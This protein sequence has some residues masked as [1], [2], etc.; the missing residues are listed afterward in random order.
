MKKKLVCIFAHPDDETFMVGGTIAKLAKEY[1]IYVL[2]ATKGEAG[3][4]SDEETKRLGQMRAKELQNAADILGIKQVYFLGFKDGTLSNNLYHKLAEKI[5]KKLEQLRPDIILS[6]DPSGISGH[7]DHIT[8]AMVTLYVFHKVSFIKTLWQY[9]GKAE[10]A[11]K[12]SKNY[13]IHF[14]KGYTRDEVDKVIDIAD[15][16]DIKVR[17]MQQHKSQKHDVD[18]ILATQK[19][20]PKEDYFF[21]VKK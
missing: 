13:F 16:W 5:Q 2:C 20:L 18:R 10:V 12:M 19:H 15:V 9:C 3:K 21:V 7:I 6:N 14:P 11:E 8:I 1:D 17:A 4:N